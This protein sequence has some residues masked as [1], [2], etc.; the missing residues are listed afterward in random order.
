MLYKLNSRLVITTSRKPS[1]MTRTFS[2]FLN[3]FLNATYF[4]RGKAS[5]TKVVNQTRQYDTSLLVVI[6]QTKGNPSSI[7]VYNLE[8]STSEACF[9]IYVNVSLPRESNKINT[10]KEDL[11]LINKCESLKELCELLEPV[12]SNQ[13]IRENCILLSDNENMN[14]R[15]FDKNSEDTGFKVYIK[16]FKINK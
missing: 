5:F 10:V 16:G 14:A 4:N 2:Q 9:S 6:N 7:N 15:F 8:D 3:H 11:V 12:D 1:Q 13:K